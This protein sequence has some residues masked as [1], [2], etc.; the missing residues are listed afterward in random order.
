MNQS[1]EYFAQ[2]ALNKQYSHY[3]T[4]YPEDYHNFHNVQESLLEHHRNK[5][6]DTQK[7]KYVLNGQFRNLQTIFL[8]FPLFADGAHHPHLDREKYPLLHAHKPNY[9]CALQI[10]F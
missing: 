4:V 7:H 8:Q 10:E 2:S 9:D 5:N 6:S 3:E 1:K